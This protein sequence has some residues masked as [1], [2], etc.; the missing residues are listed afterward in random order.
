MTIPFYDFGGDGSIL[1]FAHAN[2]FPPE[3]YRLFVEG[4]LPSFHVLGIRQRPL[5]PDSQLDAFDSWEIL[6]DDLIRFLDQEGLEGVIGVGHSVGAVATMIAA[7]KRPLLFSK[8]IL[9]EPVF[10]LPSLLKMAAAHP[11]VAYQLPLV[12]TAL[13]RRN[14]WASRQ[15]AFD[16]FRAKSFFKRWPDE[17]LWEYMNAGLHEVADGV[18]LTYSREWEASIYAHP[19]T[20]VWEYIPRISHPTLIIRG[21]DSDTIVPQVWELV[22]TQQPQATFVEIK[23]SGHMIPMERPLP[24]AKIMLDWLRSR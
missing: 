16:L 18:A 19:P 11:G 3:S 22:Q 17:A 2:G 7:R 5:W 14:H 13:R 10:L 4:L 23:K 6:A 12:Q 1:H 15:E 21:A 24:L 8:L 9:I 20:M